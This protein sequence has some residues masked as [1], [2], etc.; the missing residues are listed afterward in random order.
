MQSLEGDTGE[1]IVMEFPS[2]DKVVNLIRDAL[3]HVTS[4]GKRYEP[5][6]APVFIRALDELETPIYSR[7]QQVLLLAAAH[8]NIL[9]AKKHAIA[10]MIGDDPVSGSEMTRLVKIRQNCIEL[11]N[12]LNQS[13][14]DMKQAHV[15]PMS[16]WQSG[17]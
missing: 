17:D 15:H 16:R 14:Q 2:R 11:D 5:M 12:I 3:A 8:R 4:M 10:Q 7:H 9:Q 6:L 1:E 13:L